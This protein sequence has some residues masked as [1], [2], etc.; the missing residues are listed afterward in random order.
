MPLTV[1]ING[2]GIAGTALANFLLRSRQN[3]DI[4]IVE[5]APK[6]R[7]GG[8]QLDL[9]SYGAPLM[10]RLGLIDAVGARSIHETALTI[11]DTKGRQW[12]S[13]SI[14]QANKGLNSIT[15]E[16][17][18][19]REDLVE[20]LYEGSKALAAKASEENR[21]TLR[22]L[23]GKHAVELTQLDSKVSVVFSDG[24]SGEYDLVVAADG[25]SS[26][27]RRVLWE[28]EKN[29][30][31]AL[32]DTGL[33]VAYYRIRK[34][35][36]EAQS[37]VFKNCLQ[38]GPKALSLR[39]AH[40]D[41]TQVMLFST[42]TDE[43]REVAKRPMKEQK[44]LWKKM[45]EGF[46]WEGER[47]LTEMRNAD[48]FYTTAI[49]Q[50]KVDS[51]SKGRVVLLGDAGYCPSVLTGLGT[52]T[53]LVGA[54][55]LAGELVRHGDDVGTALKSYE[56][57]LR[58]YVDRFQ[59]LPPLTTGFFRSRLG[60]LFFYLILAIV[61]KLRLDSLLGGFMA[62]EKETWALPE[63]PELEL[64]SEE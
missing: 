62:D 50:V 37:T 55:V 44:A 40:K 48:D 36:E 31:P 16:Y 8:T 17:E 61:S 29:S 28:A 42:T 20:V 23:F 54:Y 56:K 2:A 45:Y 13:F 6:F 60:L 24:S 25:Q 30:D 22:Y 35:K 10:R 12:A 18:I 14:N 15:S 51:W 34:S 27:T 41:F 39:S 7:T 38:P 32:R 64:E 5:R 47:V 53:S 26:L 19:M 52:T 4:T 57:V 59:V 43:L 1:L 33:S 21:G 3:Y 58:P 49:A 9:K 63:Y 11:V 46:G